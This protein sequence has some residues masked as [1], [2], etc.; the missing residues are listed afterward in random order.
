[1]AGSIFVSFSLAE[2]R[3][4]PAAMIS[5]VLRAQV[6]TQR[7]TQPGQTWSGRLSP[8]PFFGAPAA[9]TRASSSSPICATSL[10]SSDWVTTIASPG[11]A[12]RCP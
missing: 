3:D 5:F 12:A 9:G 2:T 11:I 6:C 4:A 7:C 8:S 10:S 1:M